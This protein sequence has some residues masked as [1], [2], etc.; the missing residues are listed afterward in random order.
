MEAI[1]TT[2]EVKVP[3][4]KHT[5]V[6]RNFLT[7]ADRRK[8]RRLIWTLSE[9]G[10][11]RSADAL[12]AAE[13]A[14]VLELIVSVDDKKEGDPVEGSDQPFSLVAWLEGLQATDYDFMIDLINEIAGGLDKKKEVISAGSTQTSS[15]EEK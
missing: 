11:G 9:E 15:E 1:E 2:R 4:G 7:G 6:A 5:V 12:E 10:K 8:N 13:N 14:L 3:S